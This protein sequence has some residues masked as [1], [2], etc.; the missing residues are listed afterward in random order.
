MP[1]ASSGFTVRE[2]HGILLRPEKEILASSDNKAWPSVYASLQ[3]EVPFEGS[4][5]SVP[6]QLIVLHLG[7]PIMV[8]RR[9]QKGEASRLIPPGGLF[10]MPGGMDFGVRTSGTLPTLHLYLRRGLIEEVAET[11]LPG[12]PA[13]LEL[14]PRFGDSDPLIERLMLGVRDALYDEAP[15]ATPYVDYL[16]RAIAARLLRGHSS[17]SPPDTAPTR[18]GRGQLNKA[19]EYMEAHLEQSIGL[20]AI[21]AATGLSPSHFARQFR[22]TMGM[23]P[24]QYL[25]RLRIERAL[26]LLD[27]TDTPVVEIA[28]TCGFANQEHLTRLFK[29]S[30]GVTPAAYRRARRS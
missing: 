20:T 11:I 2:T 1:T 19:I 10:M 9:I 30:R 5:S 15:S 28:F 24:H 23:A 14:L 8:H 25:M 4:F 12:E 16:G 17:A 7:G 13:H 29:R 21:A 18:L 22:T 3:R 27:E 6:D 26:C